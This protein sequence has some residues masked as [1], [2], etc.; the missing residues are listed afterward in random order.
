VVSGEGYLKV[1]KSR[2][3]R[4]SSEGGKVHMLDEQNSIQFKKIMESVKVLRR[5][6]EETRRE[7]LFLS[8]LRSSISVHG[9]CSYYGNRAHAHKIRRGV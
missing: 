2:E 1:M 9:Q 8:L 7:S 6:N 4:A 5:Q 3:G